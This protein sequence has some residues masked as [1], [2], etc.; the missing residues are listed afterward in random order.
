MAKGRATRMQQW[1]NYRIRVTIQD[2]RMLVG[3]FLAFDRHMNLCIADCEE[4]RKIKQKNS[5][6]ETELKRSLG[7]VMIRGENIVALTAEAPPP[8]EPKKVEAGMILPGRAQ[9]AGRGMPVA[10]LAAAPPGL[11][12]PIRGIGGPAPDHMLSGVL[13]PPPPQSGGQILM[14]P[15]APQI[16]PTNNF[17]R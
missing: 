15:Q 1:I 8:A 9:P 14:P 2:K 4:F 3:T 5:N 16:L 13:A 12:G 7:F 17:M 11:A 10:P 6:E